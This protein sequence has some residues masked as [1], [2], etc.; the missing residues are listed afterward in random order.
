MI[1]D[2]YNK[3]MDL[4]N[5]MRLNVICKSFAIG[6]SVWHGGL[7]QAWNL[8][9]VRPASSPFPICSYIFI[10]ICFGHR[11]TTTL[12]PSSVH[13]PRLCIQQQVPPLEAW[14]LTPSLYIQAIWR[15]KLSIRPFLRKMFRKWD[16]WWSLE[17]QVE[18]LVFRGLRGT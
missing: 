16:S 4:N 7:R 8:G 6:F 5:S 13:T 14:L 12:D 2:K 10:P 9:P 3:L 15:R 1:F 17:R 11:H 18:G